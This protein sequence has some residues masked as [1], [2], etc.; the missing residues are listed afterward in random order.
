MV[1]SPDPDVVY[2]ALT[3]KEYEELSLNMADILRWVKEARWRLD[4]YKQNLGGG[5]KP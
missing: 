4:Y 3:P 5:T 1:I 2:F